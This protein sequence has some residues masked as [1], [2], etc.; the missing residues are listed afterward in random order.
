MATGGHALP[1]HGADGE[2][3]ARLVPLLQDF[4]GAVIVRWWLGFGGHGFRPPMVVG[5]GDWV[6]LRVLGDWREKRRE[7][8]KKEGAHRQRRTDKEG[9]SATGAGRRRKK[10][11][12]NAALAGSYWLEKIMPL[13]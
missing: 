10:R 6:L 1:A 2:V 5:R 7:G 12:G 4:F 11:K 9:W 3:V 8:G 13:R